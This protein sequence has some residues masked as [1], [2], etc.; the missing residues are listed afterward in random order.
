MA[1]PGAQA[2]AVELYLTR[3]HYA[4]LYYVYCALSLAVGVYL[5]AAGFRR[6][7]ASGA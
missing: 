5:T 3:L 4:E 6:K 2:A 1:N 7:A